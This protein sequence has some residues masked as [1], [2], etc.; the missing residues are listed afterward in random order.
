MG[1]VK[2]QKTPGVTGTTLSKSELEEPK[3]VDKYRLFLGH[4]MWYTANVV[5]D[6][7]NTARQSS[8]HISHSGTEH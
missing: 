6:M 4:I 2:V 5:P 8:V 7:A 1:G 3:D